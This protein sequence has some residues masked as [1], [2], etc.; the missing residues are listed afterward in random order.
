[1][2]AAVQSELREVV[3]HVRSRSRNGLLFFALGRLLDDRLDLRVGVVLLRHAV[4]PLERGVG[5]VRPV[6]LKVGLAVRRFSGRP[7][8]GGCRRPPRGG[9]ALTYD[10]ATCQ[11]DYGD[12]DA[13]G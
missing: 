10:W 12:D 6:P 2:L 5:G 3:V 13:A 7:F 11:D 4:R 1:R 9:L 8:L